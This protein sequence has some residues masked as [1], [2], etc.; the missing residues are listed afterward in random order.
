MWTVFAAAALCA[1][2]LALLGLG[3]AVTARHRAGG[4]ADLA[5]LAAADR[6][7]QG[8]A[9]ACATAGR[10]AAAQHTRLVRCALRGPVADVTVEAAGP[11]FTSRVRSRAGP[12]R[13]GV[14]AGPEARGGALSD[15]PGA[16][17][18]AS[19]RACPGPGLVRRLRAP[20]ALCAVGL[21]APSA[22]GPQ[23]VVPV[24][25]QARTAVSAAVAGT[26]A[27]RGSPAGATAPWS[28][29][30]ACGAGQPPVGPS[31][32]CRV[33][34]PRVRQMRMS[35]S[36]PRPMRM[37]SC[38]PRQMRTPSCGPR[39][40]CMTSRGPRQPPTPPHGPRQG[41]DAP[42]SPARPAGACGSLAYGLPC[43]A[44]PCP[45]PAQHSP[46]CPGHRRG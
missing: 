8:P 25:R 3:Q 4:A 9:R 28:P 2:F 15:L 13:A 10:V 14:A 42:P 1:V 41:Y 45:A 16:A 27:P 26:T 22:P 43:L 37:S 23:G 5:A 33:R 7:R 31:G 19:G 11:P 29:A 35:S 12:P 46:A 18:P 36:G 30:G 21:E 44:L 20:P 32:G 6:A 38:G 34:V 24:A 39:Q 40:T 17:R